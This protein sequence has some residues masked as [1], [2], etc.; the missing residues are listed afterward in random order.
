MKPK[1]YLDLC[2]LLNSGTEE[3]WKPVDGLLELFCFSVVRHYEE[4]LQSFSEV[5]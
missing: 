4:C 1:E 3:M 5:L 2:L